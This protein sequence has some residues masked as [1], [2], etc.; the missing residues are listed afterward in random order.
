MRLDGASPFYP[1]RK[2][3][4][5]EETAPHPSSPG[6]VHRLSKSPPPPGAH[7]EGSGR[8]PDRIR[9]ARRPRPRPGAPRSVPAGREAFPALGIA[10]GPVF[11]FPGWP[12]FHPG[13]PDRDPGF[14][15]LPEASGLYPPRRDS[16]P[17]RRKPTRASGPN[18]AWQ[19]GPWNHPDDN[20]R[21]R[22]GVNRIRMGNAKMV[23]IF[24]L[25]GWCGRSRMRLLLRA[26]RRPLQGG[27]LTTDSKR[28]PGWMTGARPLRRGG[29]APSFSSRR[30]D[31]RARTC[32]A[33]SRRPSFFTRSRLPEI[34]SAPSG[35]TFSMSA[36]FSL[37]VEHDARRR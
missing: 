35:S 22:G 34:F 14:G 18:C 29:G 1:E 15:F 20:N 33:P 2:Q 28:H 13:C 37:D 21:R 10:S 24:L 16:F 27:S 8:R 17:G 12:G 32:G 23:R 25:T 4:G 3:E 7:P 19:G 36:G 9:R 26:A 31:R 6:K 11:S 30:D 5:P